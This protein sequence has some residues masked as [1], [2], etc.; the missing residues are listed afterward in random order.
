MSGKGGQGGDTQAKT[1]QPTSKKLQDARKSGDIAYSKDF[2]QTLLTLALLCYLFWN[3]QAVLHALAQLLLIPANL[4]GLDFMLGLK[5]ALRESGYQLLT[6]L[7]PFVAIVL[8]LGLFVEFFQTGLIFVPEKIVPSGKKLNVIENVKNIFTSRNLVEV[9][10]SLIKI[11][12]F[13]YLVMILVQDSLNPLVQVVHSGTESMVAVMAEL[14]EKLL[15]Y[16]A[17]FC[18]VLAAFDMLWQRRVRRKRLMMSKQEIVRENKETEGE[19]QLKHTR[20]RLHRE[21]AT[22][23][24]VAAARKASTLVVNPTHI[25]IALWYEVEETDLP[26]VLAKGCDNVALAMI[27]AAREAGVPVMRDVPLARALFTDARENQYIPS[28]LVV[29]VAKVLRLIRDF[30]QEG[31]PLPETSTAYTSTTDE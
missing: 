19:P 17:I 11:I 14:F 8:G 21:M 9:L 28:E 20:K 18:L 23:G 31:K 6:I 5:V 2:S 27:E 25:A 1:E 12:C 3:G 26:V 13:S 15:I 24:P 4:V 22:S 10:K 7:W 29:P 30:L 16:T